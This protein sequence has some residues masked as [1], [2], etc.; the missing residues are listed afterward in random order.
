MLKTKVT[1][2]I[3][4]TTILVV[5]ILLLVAGR[6]NHQ[7]E[8]R[9][10]DAVKSGKQVL[11]NKTIASQMDSMEANTSTLIRDRVTRKALMNA[12]RKA[13][14]DAADT[15]F[16]LLSSS[17]IVSRIQLMDTEGNILYSAPQDFSGTSR[18]AISNKAISQGK[19]VRGLA[20]DNDG[21]LVAAVAFPL[22]NRGQVIGAG[23]Y[24]L[25]LDAT[26]LDFA[27]TGGSEAFIINDG[28]LE[29]STN[30]ALYAALLEEGD[31]GSADSVFI[32]SL[33]NADYSITRSAIKDNDGNILA[34]LFSATDITE[35]FE[36]QQTLTWSS[37]SILGVVFVGYLIGIPFHLGRKLAPLQTCVEQLSAIARGN[38]T[39][40]I[41]ASSNDEIGQLQGA[42][43]EMQLSMRH[44]L[45][46]VNKTSEVLTD[47]AENLSQISSETSR[48]VESQKTGLNQVVVAVEQLDSSSRDI[49]RSAVQ[50]SQTVEE[51]ESN[52]NSGKEVV[53]RTSDTINA[54]MSSLNNTSVFVNELKS[55]SEKINAIL[56]VISGVAEQTNLLALNA[57][58]EAAR[59]G[60]QGRGF[61]VV[62]DEV[63]A[64]AARTQQSTDEI[65]TM[66]QTLQSRANKAV[67]AMS[68]SREKAE[69]SVQDSLLATEALENI[70]QAVAAIT[71]LNMAVATAS[72]E[73]SLVSSEINKNISDVHE[74]ADKSASSAQLL[75][76]AAS[77]LDELTKDMRDV[78]A[79]F[80]IS[81]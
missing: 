71:E 75:L 32:A 8:L 64:L 74:V 65:Q 35:G 6:I 29:Y 37:Y 34:E 31:M 12:D 11:W 77:N 49:A 19:I 78:I 73:Q 17:N 57:A 52:V 15:T 24:A 40:E 13:L 3:L 80:E 50:A 9:Y 81:A 30:Q 22:H 45:S 16:N 66:I 4:F 10:E 62:A 47:A 44:M 51:A 76:S 41:V 1:S 48:Y 63:R 25:E 38:L 2:F 56:D 58:I 26:L 55:D 59:A 7:I 69:Q 67:D 20:R 70:N 36:L 42:M 14:R 27:L 53:V 33:S 61:A 54:L 46:K 72:E 39:E 21:T 28:Q 18:L 5:G 23:I 60:E 79:T 68:Q 43:A